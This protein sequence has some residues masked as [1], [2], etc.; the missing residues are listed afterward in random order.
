MVNVLVRN[1]VSLTVLEAGHQTNVIPDTT[2][3][4]IDNAPAV[5]GVFA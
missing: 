4:R 1:T 3:C 2:A 5:R